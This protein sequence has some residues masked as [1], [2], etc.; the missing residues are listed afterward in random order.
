MAEESV[1]LGKDMRTT[2]PRIARE[3]LE[4]KEGDRVVFV[5]DI[6]KRTVCLKKKD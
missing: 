4:L 3:V 1:R 6:K 5:T 2:I